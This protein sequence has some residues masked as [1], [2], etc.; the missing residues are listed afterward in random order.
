MMVYGR[1][2]NPPLNMKK[3]LTI[4]V[5]AAAAFVFAPVEAEA[6]PQIKSVCK[7]SK[8]S[9]RGHSHN[10]N[11]NR[12]HYSSRSYAPRVYHRPVTTYRSYQRPTYYRS[13]RV[14]TYRSSRTYVRPPIPPVPFFVPGFP[15]GHCR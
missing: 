15:F 4:A 14:T 7:S 5:A 6:R 13:P 3:I 11:R 10:Y 2:T 1:S 9:Y 8:S 12:S